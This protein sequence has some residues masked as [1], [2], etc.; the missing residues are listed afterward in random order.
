MDKTKHPE[1]DV[2]T[3]AQAQIRGIPVCAMKNTWAVH[4]VSTMFPKTNI[5]Q[6]AANEEE[7]DGCFRL[8]KAEK[9]FLL[10]DDE[11]ELMQRKA[12]DPSLAMTGERLERQLL[13]WPVRRSLDPTVLFLL[14][15][16]M[17]AAISDH[18][19]DELFSKYFEKK[20]CPIGTAGKN[21][22]KACDPQHGMADASGKCVCESTRWIGGESSLCV[23]QFLIPYGYSCG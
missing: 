1:L 8:L 18:V 22:E 10:V 6:C 17:Y 19:I 14:N 20:K 23:S 12:H 5:V 16:W 2:D 9:C 4:V 7:A 15:K 11:L 21:C 3:L 13:A